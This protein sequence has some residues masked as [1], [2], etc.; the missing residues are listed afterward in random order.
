MEITLRLSNEM[1]DERGGPCL[2]WRFPRGREGGGV[3][4]TLHPKIYNIFFM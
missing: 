1:V 4:A 2:G 3:G